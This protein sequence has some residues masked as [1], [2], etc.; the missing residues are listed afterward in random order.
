MFTQIL[1]MVSSPAAKNVLLSPATHVYHMHTT[2]MHVCNTPTHMLAHI[3]HSGMC[4]HSI[5]H[6]MHACVHV[7]CAH[8]NTPYMHVHMTT[9][10]IYT[11]LCMEIEVLAKHVFPRA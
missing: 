8:V 9:Y 3:T 2:H 11:M 6:Y 4:L 1:I 10:Y 5:P 7:T